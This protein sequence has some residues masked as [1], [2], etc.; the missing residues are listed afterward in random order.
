MIPMFFFTQRVTTS[1]NIT[2][3]ILRYNVNPNQ[4]ILLYV[5]QQTVGKYVITIH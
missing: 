5:E 1:G 2:G 4:R 3:I